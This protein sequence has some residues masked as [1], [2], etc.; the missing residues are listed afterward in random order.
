MSKRNIK[1]EVE[2]VLLFELSSIGKRKTWQSN[3][4]IFNEYRNWSEINLSNYT[5][6]GTESWHFV[7]GGLAGMPLFKQ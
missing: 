1:Q 6:H 2:L 3:C 7:F 4:Y 5:I